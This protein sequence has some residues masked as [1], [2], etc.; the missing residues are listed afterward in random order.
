MTSMTADSGTK[1]G[2]VV[3][4]GPLAA[5]G[6]TDGHTL[7]PRVKGGHRNVTDDGR[8]QPFVKRI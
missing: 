1:K 3:L 2:I 7:V 5:N 6:T 4:M 8:V